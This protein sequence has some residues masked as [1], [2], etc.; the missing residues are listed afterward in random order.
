[1]PRKVSASPTPV[2]FLC[3]CLPVGQVAFFELA[4]EVL[5]THTSRPTVQSPE[6]LGKIRGLM[7]ADALR[8]RS[9][10]LPPNA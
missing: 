1:M 6:R 9:E 4:G 10:F 5:P 3:I 7:M 2:R 8:L